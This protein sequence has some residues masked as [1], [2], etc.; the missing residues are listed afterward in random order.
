MVHVHGSRGH[1]VRPGH[2]DPKRYGTEA[3][4]GLKKRKRKRGKADAGGPKAGEFRVWGVDGALLYHRAEEKAAP[5]RELLLGE[6]P[7][8]AYDEVEGGIGLRAEL[9]DLGFDTKRDFS[10]WCA[11]VGTHGNGRHRSGE[12]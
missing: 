5:V 9:G 12:D 4:M 3:A 10:Y 11:H 7:V 6:L 8:D 2:T 1:F